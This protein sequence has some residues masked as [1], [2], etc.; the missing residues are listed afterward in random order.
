MAMRAKKEYRR[1]AA[2]KALLFF[3]ALL[4]AMVVSL[5]IPLRPTSS[6]QEKREHLTPFPEFSFSSLM[7]GEYFR[8]ID[9]WFADTFPGRDRFFD[10]NKHIR[11]LYGIQSVEIHGEISQGDD[12]PDTIFTGGS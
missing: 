11:S 1:G 10:L 8:G 3:A 9:L 6:A 5:I 2:G 12:I 4:I 7:S